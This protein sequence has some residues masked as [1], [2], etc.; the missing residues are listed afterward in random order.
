MDLNNKVAIVTGGSEGYG[1]G[2]AKALKEN[3]CRVWIFSRNPE[4][5]KETATELGVKYS[6]CDITI[7]GNWDKAMKA[8]MEDEKKIDILIN[9]AGAG[10]AIKNL[11]EQT[12]DDIYKSVMTNLTGHIYGIKRAAKLMLAQNSGIIINISSVCAEH[13]WP[14]WSVYSA[15]KA[16]IEML[17]KCLHNEF[18]KNNVKITTITP[19]WGATNFFTAANLKDRHADVMD[20][21]MTPEEMGEVVVKVCTIEDHLYVPKITIMPM[22]QEIKPM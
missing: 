21:V 14:G 18:R 22:V 19:S 2:I 12:D 4:S 1:K 9:N 7:P 16:G 10:I 17:A 3:G 5:I 13:G 6:V 11:V 20:K 15:G 8:V